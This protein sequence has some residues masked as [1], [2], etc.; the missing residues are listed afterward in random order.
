M[1]KRDLIAALA[2]VDDD[3]E[4]MIKPIPDNPS[5]RIESLFPGDLFTPVVEIGEHTVVLTIDAEPV[6]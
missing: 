3:V 6:R 2:A 5:T 1:K 4:I